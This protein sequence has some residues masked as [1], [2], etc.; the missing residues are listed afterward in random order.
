MMADPWKIAIDT[1]EQRPLE[2]EWPSERVTLAT[3]DYSIVGF[4]DQVAIE[5][6]SLTDLTSTVIHNRDR[7][8][9]ELKRFQTIPFR[10]V[11]VESDMRKLFLKSSRSRAHP[12]SIIGLCIRYQLDYDIPFWFSSTREITAM[13]VSSFL[14]RAFK[15]ISRLE[16]S[17]NG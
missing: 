17:D 12:L 13:F 8:E 16:E 4:E 3:G 1:R 2:F 14:H 9:R 11:V 15:R 5:R 7:F 6:K 10:C